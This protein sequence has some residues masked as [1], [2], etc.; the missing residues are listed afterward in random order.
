MDALVKCN[1]ESVDA[2][3]EAKTIGVKAIVNVKIYV[4]SEIKK[5]IL[6]DMYKTQEENLVKDCS[7]IIY[8][9]GED[10]TLWS[11][12][13]KYCV[14]VEDICRINDIEQDENILGSK[15]LIPSKAIF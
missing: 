1:L 11:I 12:A 3:V 10:D 13:K 2:F 5:D 15:L 6:V 9:V 8:I 7:V 4:N 14:S